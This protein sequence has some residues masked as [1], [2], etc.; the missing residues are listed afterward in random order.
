MALDTYDGLKAA[1]AS[2]L[3]R[4]DLADAIP[5]FIALAEGRIARTLRVAE[6]ET[7]ASATLIDGVVD[8][9]TDFLEARRLISSGSGA[10]NTPL[11]LIT[12]DFAGS[13]Y[14]SGMAGVPSRYTITGNTLTTFPNGGSGDVTMIY[15]AKPPS[16]NVGNQTNWLLL[17]A[18]EIYLYGALVESAPFM[19]DDARVQTWMG[20]FQKAVDDLQAVDNRGRYGSSVCRIRGATP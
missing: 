20:L 18:P 10:Y 15:Y 11:E 16:L 9:P 8:L 13:N 3:M 5:D 19:G 14:A 17:K 6:M 4:D 2:W 7:T 12:P 1:V